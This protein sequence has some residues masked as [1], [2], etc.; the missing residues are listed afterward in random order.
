[1]EQQGI[2]QPMPKVK[3]EC[4]SKR[5]AEETYKMIRSLLESDGDLRRMDSSYVCQ[6]DD[7]T[8]SGTAKGGKFEADMKV[9]SQGDGSKVE[10]EVNL[11]LM[12]TPVKGLVQSTLQKK[13][14][15]LLA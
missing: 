15:T 1:M 2:V 6:F 9:I 10:I 8:L 3:V 11:P 14:D 13:L 7:K 5:S 12:L 4:Q